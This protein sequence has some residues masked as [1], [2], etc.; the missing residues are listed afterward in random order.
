MLKTKKKTEALKWSFDQA[1]DY[2]VNLDKNPE[3]GYNPKTVSA[4]QSRLKKKKGG[5][6]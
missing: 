2:L 5:S 6:K 1:K 4:F 3:I